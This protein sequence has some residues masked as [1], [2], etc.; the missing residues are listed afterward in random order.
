MRNSSV[1]LLPAL[2]LST[3]I[4]Y[5]NPIFDGADPDAHVFGGEYWIYPTSAGPVKDGFHAYSSTDLRHWQDRGVALKL[6]DVTWIHNDGRPQRKAWAPG[7]IEQNG[8]YYFYYAV[9]PQTPTK[10]SRIGVAEGDR[11]EGPFLDSGKPL[12]TGGHGFEAIDPMAFKDPKTGAIYLYGGGSAGAKLRVWELNPDMESLKREIK[13]E[14]P[15]YFTE[16]SFMHERNGI[17]YLSYSH[18][19]TN[20]STYSVH[21]CTAPTPLGPWTYRGCIL[22]SDASHQ[23]PGHHS[24]LQNPVTG[25]WFIVYHRWETTNPKGPYRG[26]RRIAIDRLEYNA[27]GTIRPIVMTD[28]GPPVSLL[29]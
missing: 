6:A 3:L 8:K 11:P 27:D 21:Y 15:P 29:R 22:K 7:V 26:E 16:G 12:V 9:G 17:Y 13:V 19:A 1:L 14:T 23:G 28:D 20:N 25:E 2:F 18:G 5:A 24:F 4:G 10:P